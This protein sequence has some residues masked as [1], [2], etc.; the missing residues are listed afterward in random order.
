MSISSA[1]ATTTRS[2]AQ[3]T[4]ATVALTLSAATITAQDGGS[5]FLPAALQARVRNIGQINDQFNVEV[6]G[7]PAAWVSQSVPGVRMRPGVD[8]T[9][10]LAIQP[11]RGPESRAGARAFRLRVVPQE[12]PA[13]A[14]EQ[15]VTLV[16]PPF[17]ATTLELVE[18]VRSASDGADFQAR[19]YNGGN[20]PL[21]YRLSVAPAPGAPLTVTLLS[22]GQPA[23]SLLVA[24][25]PG[26]ERRCAI[27]VAARL[28]GAS[29]WATGS[30]AFTLDAVA[31]EKPAA[32]PELAP[33][34]LTASGT[35]TLTPSRPIEAQIEPR[36][37]QLVDLL[38]PEATCRLRLTNPS[39][40][41]VGVALEARAPG[42]EYDID[43]ASE[44]V[45]LEPE[46]ESSVEITVRR[47][48]LAAPATA[49]LRRP[50]QPLLRQIELPPTAGPDDVTAPLGSVSFAPAPAVDV[51]ILPPG[52]GLELAPRRQSGAVGRYRLIC[53][54]RG[55]QPARVDLT[56]DDPGYELEYACDRPMAGMMWMLRRPSWRPAGQPSGYALVVAPQATTEARLTVRPRRGGQP[57]LYSF[58]V[59]GA[60]NG[61][62][63]A[64]VAAAGELDY[65]PQSRRSWLLLLLLPLLL[66]FGTM[67][68]NVG[69]QIGRLDEAAGLIRER[70]ELLIP[71]LGQQN[72]AGPAIERLNPER[73]TAGQRAFALQVIGAN[74]ADGAS[75]RLN[76]QPRQTQRISPNE[77]RA[78]VTQAD[79]ARPGSLA[80]TVV[81]PDG[82]AS[83]A[84]SL[85]VAPPADAPPDKGGA[86]PAIGRVQLNGQTLTVAGAGFAE[87]A[88]AQWDGAAR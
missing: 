49:P 57:R 28:A 62:P 2:D 32:W 45:V 24:L 6:D 26:E 83:N 46:S 43:L 34:P 64:G 20:V 67:V 7:L 76:G 50:F 23:P 78:L 38:A 88:T 16:I 63:V 61:Q 56:L 75:V 74:F 71:Q 79:I 40:R 25:E 68:M 70:V 18:P 82:A 3:A 21:T 42:A 72:P 15:E 17:V 19:L 77:L 86:K 9:L 60:V 47:A 36:E 1:N 84:A 69:A 48:A 66:A 29:E 58:T 41:R 54:N 4:A 65:R 81:N 33:P 59:T 30:F 8:D 73:V 12:Q 51:L 10:E 53:R 39:R 14:V 5:Q 27:S 31:V 11:P 35:L 87:G 22:D 44:R 13:G 80:V 85:T 37:L 55:G 52:L